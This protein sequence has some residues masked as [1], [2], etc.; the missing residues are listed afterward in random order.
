[1]EE[2]INDNPIIKQTV[3]YSSK[4]VN[5]PPIPN[6]PSIN[7]IVIDKIIVK[8]GNAGATTEINITKRD[9]VNNNILQYETKDN[10]PVTYLWSYK[11]QHLIAEIVNAT[12]SD[13]C[14]KMGNGNEQTGKTKLEDIAAKVEPTANDF[15]D[16]NNLRTQLPDAMIT[17]Y[18]YKPLVGVESITDSHGITT[19][20]EYDSFGRLTDV[21]IGENGGNTKRNI[22]K[23]IYN[24]K[25]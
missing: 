3:N 1:M 21:K 22:E 17:T 11:N 9:D 24:Y 4:P 2:K 20:Y 25:Q 8:H 12:Y 14:K 10:V 19:F 23:Y 5:F 18:K 15:I 16:I 7:N 13:A 6:P